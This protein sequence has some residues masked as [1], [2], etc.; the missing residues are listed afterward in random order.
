M[1]TS[2]GIHANFAAYSAFAGCFLTL[3]PYWLYAQTSARGSTQITKIIV[4]TGP[5]ASSEFTGIGTSCS[6]FNVNCYSA[7]S[8]VLVACV[9]TGLLTTTSQAVYT[10]VSNGGTSGFRSSEANTIP[11]GVSGGN[12][13]P[14]MPSNIVSLFGGGNCGGYLKG[15]G[16][17]AS[18]P[19]ANIPPSQLC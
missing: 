6:N 13:Q 8:N 12:T 16:T 10:I 17:C 2:R 9:N 4:G 5:D 3:Q 14:A 15:D 1:N 7:T 11:Y 19:S 18:V